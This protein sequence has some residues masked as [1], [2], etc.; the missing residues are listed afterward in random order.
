MNLDDKIATKVDALKGEILELFQSSEDTGADL[1][2]MLRSL[3]DMIPLIEDIKTEVAWLTRN[4]VIHK[5]LDEPE[6]DDPTAPV[7][8]YTPGS[9]DPTVEEVIEQLN[10]NVKLLEYL[11][12]Q[13]EGRKQNLPSLRTLTDPLLY[14]ITQSI[15]LAY[16]WRKRMDEAESNFNN[17]VN[18]L[19]GSQA[20]RLKHATDEVIAALEQL[21]ELMPELLEDVK[22]LINGIEIKIGEDDSTIFDKLRQIFSINEDIKG[23]TADIKADTTTINGKVD[24]MSDGMQSCCSNL[25]DKA[26]DIKSDTEDISRTLDGVDSKI[27]MLQP[28]TQANQSL[29]VVQKLN[30]TMASIESI[31]GLL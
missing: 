10:D 2:I 4:E 22:D 17:R 25:S 7:Q 8:P 30:A 1:R 23:D 20:S 29:A 13:I 5:P 27:D 19:D 21:G 14:S 6:E 15:N 12:K 31:R 3:V 18:Q 16:K 9:D 28:S 24:D 26:D 11:K